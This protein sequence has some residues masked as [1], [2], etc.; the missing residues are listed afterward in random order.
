MISMK[1]NWKPLKE[2]FGFSRRERRASFILLILTLIAGIL[3][4]GIPSENIIVEEIVKPGGGFAGSSG[5]RPEDSSYDDLSLSDYK[6]TSEYFTAKPAGPFSGEKRGPGRMKEGKDAMIRPGAG[7]RTGSNRRYRSPDRYSIQSGTG[8]EKKMNFVERSKIDINKC[9]SS[10]L[11]SLPGIGPKLAARIIK[12]RNL[13]GGFAM[14]DQLR[15]V[16]GLSADTYNNIREFLVAESSA[17][18]TIDINA[19]AY[20]E[21]VRHPYF[22]KEEVAAILKYRE[23]M[24]RI[25]S[26]EALIDNK[27]I[28]GEKALKLKPYLKFD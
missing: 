10:G 1:F 24:G 18:V 17:L 13:L 2:W 25:T 19:A 26:I 8:T 23:L 12:Y 27:V 16:Y 14:V 11:I 3:R 28:S 4:F 9:D 20:R 5:L 6:D 22:E 21:L 15:E 7:V